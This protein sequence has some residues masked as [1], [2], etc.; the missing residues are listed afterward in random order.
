[1]D[2]VIAVLGDNANFPVV[3]AV[4]LVLVGIALWQIRSAGGST[5]AGRNFGDKLNR[6]ILLHPDH[7]EYMESKQEI[8]CKNHLPGK[9][10]RCIIDYMRE[11][12]NEASLKAIWA[13]APVHKEEELQPYEL[14]VHPPQIEWFEEQGIKVD[15]TTKNG[16]D[17]YKEVSRVMRASFD[18]AIRHEKEGKSLDYTLFELER[19][20]NC[21]Y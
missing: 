14:F 12:T 9:G 18:W 19:C 4:V 21:G 5:V 1:M 20:V 11:E 16:P 13:E 10:M 6:E 3:L 8:Y 17:M 15:R 2:G 7:V